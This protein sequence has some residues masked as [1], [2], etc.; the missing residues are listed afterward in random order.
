MSGAL[1]TALSQAAA[2]QRGAARAQEIAAAGQRAVAVQQESLLNQRAGDLA[3]LIGLSSDYNALQ[4]ALDAALADYDFLRSKAAEARLKEAQAISVGSLQV[5]DPAFLP[6]E[7]GGPSAL[8]LTLLVAVVSLLYGL[9]AAM[10]L[11]F[12]S[13]TPAQ[14]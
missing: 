13:P 2:E 9:V 6:G 3:Q 7:P 1:V 14:S 10:L 5:V 12:V 8:R 4:A 11:E